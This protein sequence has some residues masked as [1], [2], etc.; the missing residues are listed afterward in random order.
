MSEANNIDLELHCETGQPPSKVPESVVDSPPLAHDSPSD[1]LEG[2]TI[3]YTPELERSFTVHL[4][5]Q[6][7]SE[8]ICTCIAIS[9]DERYFAV[10]GIGRSTF[11]ALSREMRS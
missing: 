4:L 2:L 7:S 5:H 9:G 11:A 1:I 3:E 8:S 10:G 6:L